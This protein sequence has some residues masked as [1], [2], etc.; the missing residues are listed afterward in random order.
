MIKCVA[1]WFRIDYDRNMK[2]VDSLHLLNWNSVCF[3]S[4]SVS[5]LSRCEFY[6][7]LILSFCCHIGTLSHYFF[8]LIHLLG[9]KFWFVFVFTEPK[10]EGGVIWKINFTFKD[11]S[12]FL[13]IL[14]FQLLKHGLVLW[15]V[16]DDLF[17]EFCPVLDFSALFA[18]AAWRPISDCYCRSHFVLSIIVY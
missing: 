14:R 3:I 15:V 10:R 4:I 2:F 11:I 9:Q 8:K 12:Q 5:M 18:W 7:I 16:L 1:C 13:L 17:E 6:S